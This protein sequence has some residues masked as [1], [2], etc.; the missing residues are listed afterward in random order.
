MFGEYEAGKNP[1]FALRMHMCDLACSLNK[2]RSPFNVHS[3]KQQCFSIAR[4]RGQ[5]VHKMFH[6]QTVGKSRHILAEDICKTHCKTH[7]RGRSR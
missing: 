5:A 6:E 7:I 2:L 3:Y 4:Y 1:I